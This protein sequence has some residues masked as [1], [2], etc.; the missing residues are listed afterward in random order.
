M[1]YR[2]P[3]KIVEALLYAFAAIMV[4]AFMIILVFGCTYINIWDTGI[5]LF[6]LFLGLALICVTLFSATDTILKKHTIYMP[7]L[8]RNWIFYFTISVLGILLIKFGVTLPN[9]IITF[10][11][12]LV[13]FFGIQFS[14]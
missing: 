11:I 12:M 10:L 4:F 14:L 7:S 5:D 2:R 6:V 13:I 9:K 8:L 3:S 1:K